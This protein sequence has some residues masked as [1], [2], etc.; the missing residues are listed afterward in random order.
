MKRVLYLSVAF[1]IV[2]TFSLSAQLQVD[3]LGRTFVWYEI[4]PTASVRTLNVASPDSTA[5]LNIGN[6]FSIYSKSS[7]G[8]VGGY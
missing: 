4:Q 7:N 3:S 2:A 1:V 5:G 8:F 6:M